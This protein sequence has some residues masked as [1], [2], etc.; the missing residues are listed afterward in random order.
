MGCFLQGAFSLSLS[1]FLAACPPVAEPYQHVVER[2]RGGL[3][4]KAHRLLYHST[5][6]SA[7][8]TLELAL[9]IDG[10]VGAIRGPKVVRADFLRILRVETRDVVIGGHHGQRLLYA[11]A[12]VV[13]P[14]ITVTVAGVVVS[15]IL[16]LVS[17]VDAP[18]GFVVQV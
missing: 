8:E 9:L 4:F 7:P 15:E 13:L 5:I 11:F 17:G 18:W 16:A 14:V 12:R 6:G 10:R 1:L 2:F 3:V